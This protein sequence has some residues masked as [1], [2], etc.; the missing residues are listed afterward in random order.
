LRSG[1]PDVFLPVLFWSHLRGQTHD[2]YS[3]VERRSPMQLYLFIFPGI[4]RRTTVNKP[5]TAQRKLSAIT[6][7]AYGIPNARNVTDVTSGFGRML[8][9][10]DPS[11]FQEILFCK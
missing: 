2:D 10:R 7:S 9:A 11:H 3:R 5:R 1:A 6:Y 8:P 4:I